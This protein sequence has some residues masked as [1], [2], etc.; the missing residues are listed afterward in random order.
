MED[1]MKEVVAKKLEEVKKDQ[2]DNWCKDDIVNAHQLI[3]DVIRD[4]E[5]EFGLQ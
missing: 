3:K 1:F 2:L 5:K 4:L